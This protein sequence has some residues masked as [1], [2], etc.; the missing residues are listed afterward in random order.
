MRIYR[1]QRT[2]WRAAVVA[3]FD[4]AVI[5]LASLVTGGDQ[6]TS[7]ATSVYTLESPSTL[8]VSGIPVVVS[9]ED[10]SSIYLDGIPLEVD[11][12]TGQL[13]NAL[14]VNGVSHVT[15][16]TAKGVPFDVVSSVLSAAA[17]SGAS[18]LSLSAGG[19]G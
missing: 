8:E 13:K 3:L 15:V 1:R 19:G 12:L 4:I 6:P 5:C 9:V 2:L 18:S 16:E 11:E 14:S 10:D 17:S 7:A